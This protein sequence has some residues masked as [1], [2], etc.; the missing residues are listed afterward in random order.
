M[1]ALDGH[2]LVFSL[3]A[4][5]GEIVSQPPLYQTRVEGAVGAYNSI[6]ISDLVDASGASEVPGTDGVNELYV[7]GSLGLR[8]W[9]LP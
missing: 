2:L 1:G 4:V 8:R 6:V 7:A 5:T 3:D 9:S